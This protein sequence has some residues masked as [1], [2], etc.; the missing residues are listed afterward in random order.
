MQKFRIPGLIVICALLLACSAKDTLPRKKLFQFSHRTTR[1]LSGDTLVLHL[2]NPLACPLRFFLSSSDT[3]LAARL[4]P[5]KELLLPPETAREL[6]IPLGG[7]APDPALPSKVGISTIFGDP[8]AA[9]D[10]PPLHY[11]FPSGRTYRV[12]QGYGGKFSHRSAYSRYAVD[13][14]LAVGDTVCAAADG[15]VVGVIEGYSLGGPKRAWRDYANFITLY[16][17]SGFF[18]QY[19]HLKKDGSLVEV[20]DRVRANEPIG[21]SGNTGFTSTPHLHFNVLVP[22][23]AGIRSAPADFADGRT[24]QS[25]KEGLK[26]NKP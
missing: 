4:E 2:D 6:L 21:L 24:G 5:H 3:A 22:T 25:L 8:A 26:I 7:L 23:H 1:S 18:T 14:S 17:G 19:V 10:I 11:P 9:V 20:G 16:H 15:V 12:I 13:F